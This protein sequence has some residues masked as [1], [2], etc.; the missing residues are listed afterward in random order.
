MHTG[1]I[2]P[3]TDPNS[4][5]PAPRWQQPTL[6]QWLRADWPTAVCLA[7][8]LVAAVLPIW[9]APLL[10][11]MD[12]PQHLATARILHSFGDPAFGV[13]RYHVIDF[14]RTQ[15]LLWYLAVDGLS[16]LMPLETANR[17][18]LSLY[19]SGL[20]LS[21]LALLRAHRRDPALALLA[22]PLVYNVFYFMGFANYITALPLLL[23][24][25]A[26]LQH[27]LDAPDSRPRWRLVTGTAVVALLL[28]YSH[29]QAFALY[30]VLAGV[31]VLLGSPGLHP[32]H[33]WRAALH[34]VPAALAM[35]IWTSR[36]LILATATEWQKGHGGRNV[37]PGQAVWEPISERFEHIGSW[38]LD[39]YR[40]DSDELI[41]L[42]W[43]ALLILSAVLGTTATQPSPTGAQ[44]WRSKVP[45]A[46]LATTVAAYLLSPVS[47][48]WIWPI[49]YR[50]VPVAALLAIVTIGYRHLRWRSM[51]LVGPATAL[52]L[53]AS[54][55]HVGKAREF[56]SEVGPIREIVAQALPG[57]KLIALVY[58]PGSAVLQQAPLI[59]I[60]QYY[61]VDRGGMASFSFANFPQSPVLYPDVGGPPVF[62]ARFEWTPER[63]TWI[64]HGHWYDYV[65]VRGGGEP[66][67]AD[68]HKVALVAELG[69]Y[70]LFANRAT[71]AQNRGADT[72][73]D[74]AR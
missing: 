50:F 26:L 31:T 58:G 24:A 65:L 48:K 43:L 71:V 67:G 32:R 4:V 41:A 61:V 36:S 57:K 66:F 49:S 6:H 45:A 13:D 63:F 22:V 62:P 18:V 40:G 33:W 42:M 44:P 47:Y 39:G 37:A 51:V 59:H 35:A 15:Y 34:L 27:C 70:R 20:P 2:P 1:L 52:A 38:W 68:R 46:M 23:W 12:L 25:L 28:F 16:W 64:E 74:V 30:G 19:A 54:S 11:M 60:G 56:A 55:V 17:V 72:P 3:A 14:S 8:A 73:V 21:V 29:A 7:V 5:S 9:A 10:P 69:P 53:W